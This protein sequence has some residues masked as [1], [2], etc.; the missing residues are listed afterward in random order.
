MERV[1]IPTLAAALAALLVSVDGEITTEEK[2]M[3]TELG[4]KMFPGFSPLSFDVLLTGM[5]DL[6]TAGELAAKLTNL[7]EDEGKVKIMKYLVALAQA[8]SHLAQVEQQALVEV[9][10]AL[11]TQ[12]PSLTP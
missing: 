1:D 11:G 9:A 12:L 3:A 10:E 7:L 2:A 6:P 5:D 8:D 4:R